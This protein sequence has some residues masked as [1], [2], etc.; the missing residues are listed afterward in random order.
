MTL[1]R[2]LMFNEFFTGLS[3][4]VANFAFFLATFE[5]YSVGGLYLP[6]INGPNEGM[7]LCSVLSI[8]TGFIGS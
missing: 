8:F 5:S 3:V 4:S 6:I 2:I 7:V 1:S